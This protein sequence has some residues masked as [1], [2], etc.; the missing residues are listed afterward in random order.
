MSDYTIEQTIRWEEPVQVRPAG[1]GGA[2]HYLHPDTGKPY[3]G[4]PAGRRLAESELNSNA[5]GCRVCMDQHS[6][7]VNRE[8][9]AAYWTAEQ[10]RRAAATADLTTR[11]A[12]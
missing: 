2:V 6:F 9:H 10:Q 5:P 4:K 8:R 7:L 11:G 3:C 1:R 12:S